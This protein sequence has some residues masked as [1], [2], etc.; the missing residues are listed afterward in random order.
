MI[1]WKNKR[2]LLSCDLVSERKSARVLLSC[3]LL[4]GRKETRSIELRGYWKK[5]RVPAA[6]PLSTQMQKQV[7]LSHDLL[8]LRRNTFCWAVIY[9]KKKH[10]LLVCD[11]LKEETR[12]V[13]GLWSTQRRNTFCWAVICSVKE[14]TRSVEL[15]SAQWKKKHV[16]LGC[17]LLKEEPAAFCKPD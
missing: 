5:K 10:V 2:V 11:L 13:A 9:W 1:Y 8:K 17:A 6:E 4:K 16:L 7:L 14:E 15:R 3:Y 12:S